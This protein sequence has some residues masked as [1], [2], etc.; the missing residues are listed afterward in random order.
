LVFAYSI[1]HPIEQTRWVFD[2]GL[3]FAPHDLLA[4]FLS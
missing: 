4:H 2:V 3:K 1:E